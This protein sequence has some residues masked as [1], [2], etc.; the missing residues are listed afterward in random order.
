MN[1]SIVALVLVLAVSVQPAIAGKSGAGRHAADA[2]KAK[3][4]EE[5]RYQPATVSNAEQAA[6]KKYFPIIGRVVTVP[7]AR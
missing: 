2:P 5:P 4:T 7:C 3:K 1:K 6:C